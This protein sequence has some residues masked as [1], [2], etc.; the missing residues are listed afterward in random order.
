[1]VRLIAT[2]LIA[3]VLVSPTV[4]HA[5]AGSHP[6]NEDAA[7]N[8][9]ERMLTRDGVYAHRI[10]LDCITYVTEETT[11]DYF[12]FALREKHDAKCGGD[13]EASPIVDRY[14]VARRSGKIQWWETTE[15]KW[16]PYDPA[17][18]R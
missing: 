7:L 6:M 5:R 9:L 17:K 2:T 13:P 3:A 15:D 12:Q 14:R 1:M 18:I 8:L 4:V 11:H 16:L 10:S